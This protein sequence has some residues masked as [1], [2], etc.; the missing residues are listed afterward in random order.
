LPNAAAKGL[1]LCVT[2]KKQ[3]H[4]TY[5]EFQI[6]AEDY[7]LSGC[8]NKLWYKMLSFC[9]ITY[10]GS[11]PNTKSKR[12]RAPT[13][14]FSGPHLRSDRGFE[15]PKGYHPAVHASTI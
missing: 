11:A 7:N 3:I 1:F 8:F 14:F 15:N 4:I 13:V 9:E 10:Q 5:S 2:K 6:E 12:R